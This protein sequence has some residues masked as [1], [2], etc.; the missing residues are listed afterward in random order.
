MVYTIK[1]AA[2][3]AVTAAVLWSI[4]S[5]LVVAVPHG[6]M[7]MTGHMF[8]LDLA[9]LTWTMTTTGFLVG[10]VSWNAFSGVA[11]LMLAAIYNRLARSEDKL[12]G[13]KSCAGEV[14][15]RSR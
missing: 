2:A 1:F 12:L 14:G 11:G 5:A 4:C 3:C 13:T 9:Q 8:H 6:M 10:L 7:Q 15:A